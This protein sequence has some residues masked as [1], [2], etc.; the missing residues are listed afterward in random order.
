MKQLTLNSKKILNRKGGLITSNDAILSKLNR[1]NQKSFAINISHK[2]AEHDIQEGTCVFIQNNK[3]SIASALLKNSECIGI[4]FN[5]CIAGERCSYITQGK[6]HSS[7]YSFTAPFGRPVWV[8]SSGKPTD[9]PPNSGY[10]QIIGIS[11][12]ENEFIVQIQPQIFTNTFSF[13]DK[14]RIPI[15]YA[16]A[17]NQ[18]IPTIKPGSDVLVSQ[19]KVIEKSPLSIVTM[20]QATESNKWEFQISGIISNI[21]VFSREGTQLQL[22][23]QNSIKVDND[24]ITIEFIEPKTGIVNFCILN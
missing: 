8:G 11:I 12:N 18:T 4:A 9:V 20:E 5:S 24:S 13:K 21:R 17:I 22:N 16:T 7:S 10:M 19:D 15:L 14:K 1:I 6:S 2:I 23:H 3:L